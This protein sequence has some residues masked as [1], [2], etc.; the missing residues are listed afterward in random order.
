MYNLKSAAA[1]IGIFALTGCL[2]L[3]A[4]QEELAASS[5]EIVQ[6]GEE[7]QVCSALIAAQQY[8]AGD[9]CVH[10]DGSNLIV[11]YT[12]TGGWVLN[13]AHTWVGTSIVDMPQSRKGNPKI[14]NFPY[15]SG[16][17]TGATTHTFTVPLSTFGLTGDEVSC[18]PQIFIV[19]SHAAVQLDADG[20]GSYEQGE[21]AWGAGDRFVERGNW[22]TY[23]TSE[24]TCSDGGTDPGDKNCET[25][26]AEDTNLSTCF[27]DIDEDGDDTG[28]FNRWG[29]TSGTYGPGTHILHLYAG[30]GQC[31]L[32]NGTLVGTVKITHYGLGSNVKVTIYLNPGY[33]LADAQLYV[34]DDILPLDQNGEYTVA[35]GQ[36]PQV[37][38]FTDDPTTHVF[39]LVPNS[40]NIHIVTHATVCGF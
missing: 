25:A 29:W 35:P 11:T 23:F 27:L 34:G 37:D 2:D 39:D 20:D 22:A 21:T 40:G 10:V 19:A 26:F 15:N 3:A 14:G 38:E 9:V 30:A 36:Y 17:I 4:P 7:N 16:D 5:Q 18:D 13:E 8:N 33:T 31:D 6:V 24:L 32:S 1:C 12:T 28:D